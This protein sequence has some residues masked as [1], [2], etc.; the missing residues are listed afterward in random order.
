MTCPSR[1]G[2]SELQLAM[3]TLDRELELAPTVGATH[4]NA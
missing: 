3:A 4:V 1:P 2:R